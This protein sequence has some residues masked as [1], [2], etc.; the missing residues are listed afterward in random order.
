MCPCRQ[1]EVIFIFCDEE[2]ATLQAA[3]QPQERF[4]MTPAN[5]LRHDG[6][7]PLDADEIMEAVRDLLMSSA[8]PALIRVIGRTAYQV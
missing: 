6:A 5:Y 4:V 3:E 1:D 2:E 8:P 7:P